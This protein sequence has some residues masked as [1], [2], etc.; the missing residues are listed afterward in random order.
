MFDWLTFSLLAILFWLDPALFN[1]SICDRCPWGSWLYVFLLHLLPK[2]D[3]FKCI[4]LITFLCR[5]KVC[6]YYLKASL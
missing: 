2:K 6:T 1:A 5:F 3:Q 4:Y